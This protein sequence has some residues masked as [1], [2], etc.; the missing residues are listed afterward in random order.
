MPILTDPILASVLTKRDEVGSWIADTQNSLIR[1]PVRGM[2]ESGAMFL[3]DEYLGD[4]ETMLRFNEHGFRTFCSRVGYRFDQLAMLETPSLASQVLNDIISQRAI[5]SRLEN[6][7]FVLDKDRNCIIGMVST[8]YVGYSNEKFLG[9]IDRMLGS[10]PQDDRFEFYQAYGVNTELTIRYTSLTRHGEV[11]GRGGS[12]Q[13]VTM[14]GLEFKNSMVGTS[15]VRFSYFLHRLACANG[16]MVPAASATSRVIH[17]G[18]LD[19]FERRLTECFKEVHRKLDTVSN[20]LA[21]L[22]NLEFDPMRLA[23]SDVNY[24][25]RS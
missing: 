9:D 13:D 24:L 25:G 8:S 19:S 7:D 23:L 5:S 18:N 21:T 14:L 15:S 4:G 10:L 16:M 1:V 17:S 6:D 22:G 3:D 20:M 2:L 11:K 12:G